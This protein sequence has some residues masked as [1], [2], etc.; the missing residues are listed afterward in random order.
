[1]TYAVVKNKPGFMPDNIDDIP[2]FET[3][4]DAIEHVR[5]EISNDLDMAFELDTEYEL[6][7]LENL[8]S[9]AINDIKEHMQC[10]FMDNVYQ[11]LDKSSGD[12][13]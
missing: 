8:Q 6:E 4:N 10:W 11:I 13:L 1:M 5:Y 9:Q 7:Q 12:A 3:A 2:E